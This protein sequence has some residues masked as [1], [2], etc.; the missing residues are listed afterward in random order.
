MFHSPCVFLASNAFH[1]IFH[2]KITVVGKPVSSKYATVY[3]RSGHMAKF[4]VQKWTQRAAFVKKSDIRT[5][6]NGG[7][8]FS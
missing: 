5:S 8:T 2:V 7:Y 1:E 3:I 6:E 4:L